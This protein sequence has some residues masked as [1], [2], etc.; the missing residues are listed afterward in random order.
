MHIWLIKGKSEHQS[1]ND[2]D[3]YVPSF[4]SDQYVVRSISHGIRK[5]YEYRGARVFVPW[6]IVQPAYLFKNKQERNGMDCC[7]VKLIG[8]IVQ[9]PA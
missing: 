4:S 8:L 2:V 5:R 7:L 6:L 1:K 3:V 9:D